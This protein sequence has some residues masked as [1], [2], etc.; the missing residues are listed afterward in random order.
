MTPGVVFR[1]RSAENDSR[2]RFGA[3]T[4]LALVFA[5]AGRLGACP[6]CF[7]IDDAA[8]TSGVRAA[9]FVLMGVTITV[10]AAFGAFIIRFARRARGRGAA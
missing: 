5:F 2:S 8:T 4:T 10:L 1:K 3:V 7:Q 6:V 9:V